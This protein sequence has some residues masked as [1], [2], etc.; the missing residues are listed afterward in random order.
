MKNHIN[1]FIFKDF[2]LREIE[3]F[4]PYYKSIK[5]KL[6]SLIYYEI[7]EDYRR[8]DYF[9][10]F[11]SLTFLNNFNLYFIEGKNE[12]EFFYKAEDFK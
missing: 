9:D 4:N 7:L 12:I 1:E 10:Q 6:P 3:K 2:K 5:R 11:K 8:K